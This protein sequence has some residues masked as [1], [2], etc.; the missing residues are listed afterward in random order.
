MTNY[1]ITLTLGNKYGIEFSRGG[2]KG[3]EETVENTSFG[4]KA[5]N[6]KAKFYYID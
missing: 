5:V 2:E 1:N 6:L 4:T 3:W